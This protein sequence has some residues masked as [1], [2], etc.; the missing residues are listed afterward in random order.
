MEFSPQRLSYT[1]LSVYEEIVEL[2]R[3]V[4]LVSLSYVFV[5]SDFVLLSCHQRH[6][7]IVDL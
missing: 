2:Q 3:N 7:T 5:S 6:I 4:F 1:N